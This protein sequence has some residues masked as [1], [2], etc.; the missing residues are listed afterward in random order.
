MSR[1]CGSLSVL[2]II[3]IIII[4][5]STRNLI[6]IIIIGSTRNIIIIIGFTSGGGSYEY[7][8]LRTPGPPF[9]RLS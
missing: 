8:L 5:G 6:I 1:Y 7:V 3:I 4:I 2:G 9:A